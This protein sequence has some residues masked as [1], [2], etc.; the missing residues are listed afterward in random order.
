VN[1]EYFIYVYKEVD[2]PD[3]EAPLVS[4]VISKSDRNAYWEYLDGIEVDHKTAILVSHN[5]AIELDTD[6]L[7][8]QGD[9]IPP[10]FLSNH[11]RIMRLQKQILKGEL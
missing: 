6:I 9:D 7:G 1:T 11:S 4:A 2:T 8:Q 5:K 3:Q 10:R